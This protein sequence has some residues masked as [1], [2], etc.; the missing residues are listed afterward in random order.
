MQYTHRLDAF[1]ELKR[2]LFFR[3]YFAYS[4]AF[5]WTPVLYINRTMQKGLPGKCELLYASTLNQM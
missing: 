4:F 3:D 5:E 2:I 1:K